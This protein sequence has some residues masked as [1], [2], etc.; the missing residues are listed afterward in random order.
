MAKKGPKPY[1]HGHQHAGGV[2]LTLYESAQGAVHVA[3]RWTE[4]SME[5]VEGSGELVQRLDEI[6]ERRKRQE[7]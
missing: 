5:S 1:L 3:A 6:R 7:K 2:T 4:P